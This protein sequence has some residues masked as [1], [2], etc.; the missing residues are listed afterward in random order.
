VYGGFCCNQNAIY[1]PGWDITAWTLL[2]NPDSN[3]NNVVRLAVAKGAGGLAANSWT[4][5]DFPPSSLGFPGSPT[6]IFLDFPRVAYSSNYLYLFANVDNH[7]S[8]IY[9]SAVFRCPLAAI[10][11]ST[12]GPVTCANFWLNDP[13]TDTFTPLKG[14]TS[15]MYWVNHLDTAT[16]NVFSWPESAADYTGVT[17]GQV[18]HSVYPNS[19][20]ICTGPDGVNPCGFEDIWNPIQGGWVANGV[21]GVMWDAAQGSGG[22]GSFPYPYVHV[23]EIDEATLGLI[24][25]PIIWSANN[26]WTI[27]AVSPNGSGELGVSIAYLGDSYYPGS[28]VMVRDA[29]S[30]TAWQTINVAESTNDPPQSRWGDYLTVQALNGNGSTWVAAGYTLDGHCSDNTN[31]CASVQPRYVTFGRESNAQCVGAALLAR[32]AASQRS[33]ALL[34]HSI[35]LP[36]VPNSGCLG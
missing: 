4:Y 15:T 27:G 33:S 1:I 20:F 5:W 11:S 31:P 29:I 14:S 25:E 3:F 23:V 6:G 8:S 10:A 21:L 32:S 18:S 24:D 9:A 19:N 16:L 17:E 22:L 13:G 28:A 36:I 12:G 26:A 30:P 34:A 35:Y 2:Y 7:D